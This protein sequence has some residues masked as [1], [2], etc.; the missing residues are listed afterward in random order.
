VDRPVQPAPEPGLPDHR[1]H[2]RQEQ[3][4]DGTLDAEHRQRH[5]RPRVPEQ[6]VHRRGLARRP[7]QHN[8]RR[9]EPR[10]RP[11]QSSCENA[12]PAGK[13]QRDQAGDDPAYRRQADKQSGIPRAIGRPQRPGKVA[14]DRAEHEEGEHP[15]Q[16]LEGCG[17][18]VRGSL[19]GRGPDANG[20]PRPPHDGPGGTERPRRA[21][22]RARDEAGGAQPREQ[23][24]RGHRTPRP[25]RRRRGPA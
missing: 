21:P 22:P 7:G 6:G 20:E 16:L 23:T 5:P 1:R 9:V 2:R 12:H 8:A 11:I 15:G 13:G 25:H 4:K 19:Q 14:G 17:E 3:A 10:A 18:H 24:V